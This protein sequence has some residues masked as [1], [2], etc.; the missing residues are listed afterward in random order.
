M[1][2]EIN[3]AKPNQLQQQYADVLCYWWKHSWEQLTTKS[4]CE[5]QAKALLGHFY[6]SACWI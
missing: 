5:K 6:L 4:Q 2:S 3:N 1:K